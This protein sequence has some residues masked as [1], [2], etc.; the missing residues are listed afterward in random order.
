MSSDVLAVKQ[1]LFPHTGILPATRKQQSLFFLAIVN[2]KI[3]KSEFRE[4]AKSAPLYAEVLQSNTSPV[5]A[6]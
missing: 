3:N 5:S 6:F 4:S 2:W 1:S